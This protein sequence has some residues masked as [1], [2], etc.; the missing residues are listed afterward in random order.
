MGSNLSKVP[1]AITTKQREL[2]LAQREV[3]MA[4]QLAKLRDD[5]LCGCFFASVV[6]PLCLLNVRRTGNPAFLAPMV[7]LTFALF[8][9]YD[10]GYGTKMARVQAETERILATE[11]KRF[12]LPRGN[13]ICSP[14]D[15]A[16]MFCITDQKK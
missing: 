11:R 14:E 3:M 5:L 1:D 10:A 16:T 6:F 13:R 8:Y 2:Q 4:V 12:V 15:Y 9:M 7:P